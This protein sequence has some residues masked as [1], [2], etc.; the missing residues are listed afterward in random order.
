VFEVRGDHL[1]SARDEVDRAVAANHPLGAC[2][3]AAGL[4][5]GRDRFGL[6]RPDDPGNFGAEVGQQ[7]AAER[8]R[9]TP[10]QLNDT[11]SG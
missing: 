3:G 11:Q 1:P 9:P 5:A 2:L 6:A 8:A 4:H 10:L 7:H